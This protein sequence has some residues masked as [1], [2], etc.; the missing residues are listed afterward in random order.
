[1]LVPSSADLR[2]RR[3]EAFRQ[4]WHHIVEHVSFG[5]ELR[6]KLLANPIGPPTALRHRP[7]DGQPVP[8]EFPTKRLVLDKPP[9]MHAVQKQHGV[10]VRV[11]LRRFVD[12]RRVTGNQSLPTK[13][14]FRRARAS[15]F[16][17]KE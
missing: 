1:M 17:E 16:R 6:I 9:Q 2:R 3:T 12:I 15:D 4:I 8:I 7:Y 13:F 14:Q 5:G 10:T 11:A